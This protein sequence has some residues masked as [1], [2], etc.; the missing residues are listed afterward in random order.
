MV[1]ADRENTVRAHKVKLEPTISW[2]EQLSVLALATAKNLNKEKLH[3]LLG[4]L[5]SLT[6]PT[7]FLKIG[8][9]E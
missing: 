1:P 9:I 8:S 4:T 6:G 7:E 5:I 3:E 2:F